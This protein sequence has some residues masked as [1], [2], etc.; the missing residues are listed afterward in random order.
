M[1][2]WVDATWAGAETGTGDQP[3]N[4]LQQAHDAAPNNSILYL[5]RGGTHSNSGV[6]FDLTKPMTLAGPGTATVDP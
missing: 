3:Y 2:I 5:Q 6:D 1:M 4:N